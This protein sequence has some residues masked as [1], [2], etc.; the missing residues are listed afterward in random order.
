[1]DGA[2]KAANELDAAKEIFHLIGQDL[3]LLARLHDRELDAAAIAGLLTA[4][5]QDWLAL[6]P[7][8]KEAA[9]GFTLLQDACRIFREQPEQSLLDDLA[10]DFAGLYLT[11][12]CRASPNE[13][14]WMTEEGIERQE[15][16][17][18]VRNWYRLYDLEVPDWRIRSDDHLV[19][20]LTFLTELSRQATRTTLLDAGRFLDQHLMNWIGLFAE[21][22]SSNC[23]TPF[24]AGLALIT[25]CYIVALRQALEEVT[26]EARKPKEEIAPSKPPDEPLNEA[27]MPGLQPSW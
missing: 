15:P 19:N 8:G 7:T 4:S 21:R 18:A 17:F 1:M 16:M 26:E 22:A 23:Q 6:P 10:A 3:G 13:S 9:A 25:H 24:Y 11:H 27:F 2:E 5:P 14:V 20:Q 12:A